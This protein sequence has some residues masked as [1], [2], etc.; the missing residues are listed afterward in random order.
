MHNKNRKPASD[1]PDET[2]EHA[3]ETDRASGQLDRETV[4][5]EKVESPFGEAHTVTYAESSVTTQPFSKQFSSLGGYDILGE[6][7]R[8]AMGVVYKAFQRGLDRVVALKM[9]LAG[10]HATPEQLRRFIVE[11]KAVAHLQHPNIVQVFDIGESNGLP[12][13]S[14]EYVDGPSLARH[15]ERLPQAPE[16]AARMTEI[17]ARTMAYAHSNGVLHRD[18]KPGN[19]LLTASGVPKI[20]DFGLAKQIEDA[21]DAQS[22]RTGTIMGTPSYMAPE[23][24]R[25]DVQSVGPAADQYALGAILYEM[26]TGRPPFIAARAHETILQVIRNEPV[27]PRQLVPR[28]PKDLETICLHALQ[29]EVGSRYA[30]CIEL[31]DDLSRFLVGVPIHA[32]PVSALERTWRWC[33]RNPVVAGLSGTALAL[34]LAIAIGSSWMA[35]VL[36]SKN[37]D[38]TEATNKAV[39]NE[40][41]AVE[42]TDEAVRRSDR[43]KKLIQNSVTDVNRINLT[44]NPGLRDYVKKT[45]DDM[46]PLLEEIVRELPLTDQAEPTLAGILTEIARSYREQGNSTAA[47]AKFRELVEF[48]RRRMTIKGESDAARINLSKFLIELAA[49]RLEANRDFEEHL[50]LLREA[51]QLAVDVIEHPRGSP[52]DGKGM[53]PFFRTRAQLAEV[54]NRLATAHFRLGSRQEARALYDEAIALFRSI[55]DAIPEGRAFE[56]NSGN[57]PTAAEIAQVKA[58][59]EAVIAT[60]ELAS[61]TV[62]YRSGEKEKAVEIL[63]RALAAQRKAYEADSVP[64]KA[65]RYVGFVGVL[66]E[67]ESTTDRADEFLLDM[68]SALGIIEQI[69]KQDPR[70]AE[71]RRVTALLNYR[72]G[73]WSAR[74]G[75]AEKAAS[76][77]QRT[78]TLRRMSVDLDPTNDRKQLDWFIAAAGAG[79]EMTCE[80][81]YQRYST[82]AKIDNEMRIDLARGC[83]RLSL[84]AAEPQKWSERSLKLIRMAI[85]KGFTDP[86]H[87]ETEMDFDPLRDLPEFRSLITSASPPPQN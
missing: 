63:R 76:Y 3:S 27:P 82:F 40:K 86:I 54:K 49:V 18:L 12:F 20:A 26:L 42:Q 51:E 77:F 23:Q 68:E 17:L 9:V 60:A 84:S 78:L 81:L 74:R 39:A 29:K 10:N 56:P 2:I 69:T 52:D 67:F 35:G 22:T 83:A 33:R 41:K 61:A 59:T 47:E 21:D 50:H 79:D 65:V 45:L 53:Q 48:G 70:S 34:L 8:G 66:G 15:L 73:Q 58:G 36:S 5:W 11:A 7:G 4:E 38:L 1:L 16:A 75:N 46:I 24:A 30:G 55:L 71:K 37:R 25:G 43:L 80:S 72:L 57:K 13:F 62:L 31:A 44:D 28:I 64:S 14:L 6:L 85:E 19:I 87:L 32:R